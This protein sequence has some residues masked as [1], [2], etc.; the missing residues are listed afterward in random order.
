V[1]DALTRLFAEHDDWLAVERGLAPNTLISYRRDLRRYEEFLRA[2]QCTD[3]DRIDEATV[4]AYVAHLESLVD[5]DGRRLLSPASVARSVAAVRSLHRFASR[6]GLTPSDP[7]EEIGA[8]RVPAGIPKALTEDEVEELLGA[9]TGTDA[10]AQRDR[11]LLELLYGTG[12][13]ISEAV[14]LDLADIDL[15]SR[16]VRVFGKG[17]KERVVPIGRAAGDALSSYM[18][19]GRLELRARARRTVDGDPVFVNA[20]G[21][22]ISRQSAWTIVRRAGERVALDDRLSPHVLRHSCATHMLEHGA[23]LRVVQE[24]LGHASISTTQVYTKVTPTRLREQYEIAHPRAHKRPE[25]IR[26]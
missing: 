7:S 1:P 10:L 17:S 19:D 6:E 20:R 21:S 4:A 25:K 3:P 18:R 8:P 11:T 9:V 15:D 23:D 24:L 22:R 13:R 14:A 2:R 12:I 26:A 16:L 5:D